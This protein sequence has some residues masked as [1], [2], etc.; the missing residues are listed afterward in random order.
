M[1]F[2]LF[3]LNGCHGTKIRFCRCTTASDREQLMNARLFPATLE[4]PESAFTFELLK[5][6]HLL[7]LQSKASTYDFAETLRRFSDNA[8]PVNTIVSSILF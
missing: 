3:H 6:F 5:F 7:Q 8:F 2:Q 1:M 4:S